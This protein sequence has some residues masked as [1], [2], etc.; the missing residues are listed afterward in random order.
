MNTLNIAICED[1][2][3]EL[4]YLLDLINENDI[5]TTCTTF[6]SGEEFLKN[7]EVGMYDLIYMDIYMKGMSGIDTIKAIREIDSDV[8][9]AFTTTSLD[10][11]LESY[12]LDAIKYI[13]KPASKKVV[14]DLLELSLLKITNKPCF[15]FT[16]GSTAMS[17]PFCRIVYIE[18]Q[19]RT[20]FIYA[21]GNFIFQTNEKIDKI[22][23]LFESQSFIRCHKS[24]LVNLNF[25]KSLDKDLSVFIMKEGGNVHI[26]R[27]S[28][29]FAKNAYENHLFNKA[30]E[31][32]YKSE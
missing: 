11:T 15:S 30:R 25:I 19:G 5:P 13:E 21:T 2:R 26:R 6:N 20:L 10:F 16:Q 4:T 28:I 24:Y 14:N 32:H 29:T 18:Q 31:N 8:L 1:N 12:R 17:I 3:L 9:V 7:Y 27:E 23:H 22:E